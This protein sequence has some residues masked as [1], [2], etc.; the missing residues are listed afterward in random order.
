MA[1]ISV[2]ANFST[3]TFTV[4]SSVGTPSGNINPLG[5]QSVDSGTTTQFTLT[6]DPDY[7]IDSVG[8]TCGGSLVGDT[9]TTAAITA[10]CTVV[11]NFTESTEIIFENGF[12]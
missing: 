11:A 4:T 10:D 6:A 5:E 9:F 7:H 8:G 3:D 12:E 1:D 2:T